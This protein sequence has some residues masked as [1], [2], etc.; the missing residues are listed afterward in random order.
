MLDMLLM[1]QG[2]EREKAQQ[3]VWGEWGTRWRRATRMRQRRRRWR[4]KAR[5]N[6]KIWT[7]CRVTKRTWPSLFVSTPLHISFKKTR[8][9]FMGNSS[10]LKK[11]GVTSSWPRPTALIIFVRTEAS[12]RISTDFS[13]PQQRAQLALW[14]NTRESESIDCEACKLDNEVNSQILCKVAFLCCKFL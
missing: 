1:I 10:F 7:V 9:P 6:P 12:W 13:F 8:L 5:R 3:E 2:G 4:W 11:W 14:P